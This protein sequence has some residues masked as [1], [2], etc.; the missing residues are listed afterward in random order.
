MEVSTYVD[1]MNVEVWYGCVD[2]LGGTNGEVRF[3]TLPAFVDERHNIYAGGGGEYR[4]VKYD[5]DRDQ[6]LAVQ[7]AKALRVNHGCYLEI[8]CWWREFAEGAML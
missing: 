4:G 6:F 5:R 2:I 1:G 7:S 8:K 3:L